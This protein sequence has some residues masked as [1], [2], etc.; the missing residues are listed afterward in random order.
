[1]YCIAGTTRY[2]NIIIFRPNFPPWALSVDPPLFRS[3]LK[4]KIQ[5]PRCL[6]EKVGT[7]DLANGSWRSRGGRRKQQK[8]ETIS[9]Q[10]KWK[11]N[12]RLKRVEKDNEK[13]RRRRRRKKK[14]KKEKCRM[15]ISSPF[16][17]FVTLSF[18]FQL[19]LFDFSF[20]D[21]FFVRNKYF[22]FSQSLT[23]WQ[24]VIK[25]NF[26]HFILMWKWTNIPLFFLYLL[27][28]Y[29]FFFFLSLPL[30]FFSPRSLS[31][32]ISLSSVLSVF[33]PLRK[34][35][36]LSCSEN[37]RRPNCVEK[38]SRKKPLFH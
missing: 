17:F 1:M 4:R 38:K 35:L 19:I 36:L 2:N 33:L 16:P 29:F 25:R 20:L 21:F 37:G 32:S 7:R 8:M 30:S 23:R 31:L 24:R 10:M 3:R 26:R 13:R 27:Y 11:M 6:G 22:H 9:D 15:W 18:S 28:I 5:G 34:S 14:R 12:F